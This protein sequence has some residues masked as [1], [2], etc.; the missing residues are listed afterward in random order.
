MIIKIDNREKETHF[1]RNQEGK[2]KGKNQVV[3]NK[4]GDREIII[5]RKKEE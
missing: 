1:T 2:K 5:T 3:G 4:K